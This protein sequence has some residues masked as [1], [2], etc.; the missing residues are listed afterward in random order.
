MSIPT[1]S[2]NIFSFFS[3]YIYFCSFI[4]LSCSRRVTFD[5]ALGLCTSLTRHIIY[6]QSLLTDTCSMLSRKWQWN[7]GQV[8]YITCTPISQKIN[9]HFIFELKLFV[10]YFTVVQKKIIYILNEIDDDCTK[11]ISYKNC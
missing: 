10:F 11:K 4:Y 5:Q 2:S 8:L 7:E 6:I 9:K 3:L 1:N